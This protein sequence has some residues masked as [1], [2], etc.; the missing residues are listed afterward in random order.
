M[1]GAVNPGRAQVTHQ[2]PL[3]AEHIERQEAVMVVVA[4]EEAALLPAVNRVVGGVEVEGQ[5]LG[6]SI[7]GRDEGL[8]HNL[9]DGPRPVPAGGIVE[10]AQGRWAGQGAVAP[11]RR[12]KREIMA[13][14]RMVVDVLVAQ[15]QGVHPLAQQGDTI[16]L[17]LAPL[18][19]VMKPARHRGGQSQQPVGLAQQYNPAV[20]GDMTTGKISR[21]TPLTT[22]WKLDV[23]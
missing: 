10:A 18:A 22:G 23:Q 14:R 12:L 1:L 15:R 16:M 9:V 2:Q 8:H 11:G 4:V 13:Q 20:A 3:A 21:H 5:V 17:D 6:R 19:A 7:E